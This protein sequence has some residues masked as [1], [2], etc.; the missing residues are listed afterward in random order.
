[1]GIPNGFGT[2]EEGPDPSVGWNRASSDDK[3]TSRAA[4]PS[5]VTSLTLET[6]SRASKRQDRDSP[7]TP[8]NPIEDSPCPTCSS[9]SESEPEGF[10]F[11]QRLQDPWKTPENLQAD[12]R[13]ISR[14][15]C[16]V[17]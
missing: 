17:C 9:S 11:G 12:D 8:G 4:R 5:A 13:D 14:K 6:P 10:F 2:G 3:I 16:T 15:H 7:Q 1:M